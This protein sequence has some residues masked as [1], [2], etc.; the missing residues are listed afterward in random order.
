MAIW[1]KDMFDNLLTRLWEDDS[2]SVIAAEYLALAGIVALGGV[3]GLESIRS[4]TVDEAKEVCN[5]IRTMNQSY[6]IKAQS[7]AAGSAGG[8]AASDS[9]G[10]SFNGSP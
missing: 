5:S 4:A 7:S 10:S 3:A 6:H 8:A 1:R 2:G 9:P